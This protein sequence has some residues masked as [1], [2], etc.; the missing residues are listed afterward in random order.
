LLN[1]TSQ[2]RA[3]CVANYELNDQQATVQLGQRVSGSAPARLRA[4]CGSPYLVVLILQGQCDRQR[5]SK[6]AGH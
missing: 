4:L 5:D 6:Q 2:G 3:E 1:R